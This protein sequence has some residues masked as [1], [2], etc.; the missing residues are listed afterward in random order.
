MKLRTVI[1]ASLLLL[2]ATVVFDT[3]VPAADDPQN[4]LISLLAAGKP[5]VGIWTGATGAPRIAK[6]L[7]TS[8]ADFIVADIEHDIYDFRTLHSFLLEV[9]DFSARYRP[10]PRPAPAVLVKLAHRAGWDPRYEISE[11]MRVGPATG[12]WVPQVES[13]AEMERAISE[14]EQSEQTGL[15]GV[16]ASDQG[17]HT[18]VSPLW[19]LNPKGRLMVVAMIES[20]EG[21]KNAKEI[22]ATPGLAAIH[23]VHISDADAQKVLQLCLEHKVI[24]G[25]DA[26]AGSVKAKV[27]V[28]YKLIS[29]GWDFGMLQ[30]QMGDTIKAVR[31]AITPTM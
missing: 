26:N 14:F 3:K 7:A 1:K 22:I 12:I 15:E 21:V 29:L 25:V 5:A 19:P 31:S 20:E 10:Q 27:A 9:S 17:G 30:R 24:A 18:H 2:F 16:T 8:D 23:V 6:V 28:G 4:N 11:T 13:R